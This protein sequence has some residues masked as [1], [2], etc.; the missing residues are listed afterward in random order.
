MLS[1]STFCSAWSRWSPAWPR[2]VVAAR[3]LCSGRHQG[4][5]PALWGWK[6]RRSLL[7]KLR[8][9]LFLFSQF[10]WPLL[11]PPPPSSWPGATSATRRCR[12]STSTL[13]GHESQGTH[14]TRARRRVR[15]SSA[16]AGGPSEGRRHTRGGRS[17]A[18]AS[19]HDAPCD[20][21]HAEDAMARSGP[22][23][24]RRRPHLWLFPPQRCARSS[25]THGASSQGATN[26]ARPSHPDPRPPRPRRAYH[27]AP[28]TPSPSTRPTAHHTTPS[29]VH[30]RASETAKGQRSLKHKFAR[31]SS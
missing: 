10:F 4:K 16:R 7:I 25:S 6:G 1:R 19:G 28:C 23:G 15:P 5:H 29:R 22:T 17:E 9:R 2:C 31:A 8:T 12:M 18:V 11:P 26:T 14:A 20:N 27:R 21:R 13:S 3:A 30:R 24:R